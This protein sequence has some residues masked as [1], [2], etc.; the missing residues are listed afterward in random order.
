[1]VIEAFDRHS[2]LDLDLGSPR[3]PAING[4][5]PHARIVADKFHVLASIDRG[6]NRVLVQP[7]RTDPEFGA[8]SC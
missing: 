1:M 4:I 7:L 8:G 2:T 6:A 5:L 3:V